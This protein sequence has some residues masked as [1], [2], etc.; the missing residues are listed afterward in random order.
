[1]DFYAL[2]FLVTLLTAYIKN[3]NNKYECF[4]ETWFAIQKYLKATGGV[5]LSLLLL[6]GTPEYPLKLICKCSVKKKKNEI[7][8][9]MQL[10]LKIAVRTTITLYI[11]F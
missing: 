11:T 10:V 8:Y 4:K 7:S 1:M 9:S 3:M 2:Y 5:V 6:V